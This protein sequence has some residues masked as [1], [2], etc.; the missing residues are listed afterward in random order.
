M[1]RL[2]VYENRRVTGAKKKEGKPLTPSNLGL[3]IGSFCG[4]ILRTIGRKLTSSGWSIYNSLFFKVQVSGD[5]QAT[6]IISE[7]F[8]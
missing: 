2:G 4:D 8:M 7:N 5:F 1:S 6:H 3:F